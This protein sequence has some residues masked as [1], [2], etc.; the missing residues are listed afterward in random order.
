MAGRVEE[1]GRRD[2]VAESIEQTFINLQAGSAPEQQ[3]GN[4][5]SGD[6]PV[7]MTV[8]ERRKAGTTRLDPADLPGRNGAAGQARSRIPPA[9]SDNR[10]AETSEMPGR[11][12]PRERRKS[13]TTRLDLADVLGS[14]EAAQIRSRS[15]GLEPDNHRSPASE[16]SARRTPRERRKSG[17]T[18]LDLAD[19]LGSSEAA[20]QMRRRA[21]PAQSDNQGPERA[22]DRRQ[23]LAAQPGA[24]ELT[25]AGAAAQEGQLTVAR[26]DAHATAKLANASAPYPE[27]NIFDNG[28][29]IIILADLPGIDLDLLALTSDGRGLTITGKRRPQPNLEGALCRLRERANAP[30]VRTVPLPETLE[31]TRASA[32]YRN[33]IL[34]FRAPKGQSSFKITVQ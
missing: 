8:R 34:E 27:V 20:V 6:A 2:N 22:V 28:T 1:R 24:A 21:S 11:R 29:E 15:S 25:E 10:R 33:G 14:E 4:R 30:F 17:T 19:V 5:D 23:R 18:R 9:E 32:T 16:S 26:L 31:F 12:S 3:P 13:G 7:L